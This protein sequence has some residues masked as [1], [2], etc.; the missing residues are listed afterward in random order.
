MLKIESKR[1][2][3]IVFSLI[4]LITFFPILIIILI[5]VWQGDKKSPF[6]F[7]KRVGK[8]NLDFIMIKIRTMRIDADKCGVNSTSSDDNRITRIGHLIRRFKL[9]EIC[10]FLNVIQ[11]SMSIVGPRP[12]TRKCGVDI[13]TDEEMKLLN[14][15][16]GITDFAS[17]VFADEGAILSKSQ[18]PDLDYNLYIRF[19]KSCLGLIYIK[20]KS[21]ML[22]VYLIFL[23]IL[24][25]FNREKALHLISYKIAKYSDSYKEISEICLRKIELKK[26]NFDNKNFINYKL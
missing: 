5:A 6:Y 3:D 22:D 7:A 1:I 15:K 23:T 10:Q 9:D 18:D 14:V 26:V 19:W 20:H 25:F 12:N 8:N 17:I 13:Y 16:P 21:F 2:F 24:N 4:I 11:G